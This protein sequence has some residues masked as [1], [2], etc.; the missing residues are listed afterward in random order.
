VQL[1]AAVSA[2]DAQLAS[3]AEVMAT[4]RGDL[5]E[6]RAQAAELEERLAA[7]AAPGGGFE[8]DGDAERP[9]GGWGALASPMGRSPCHVAGGGGFAERLMEG[10]APLEQLHYQVGPCGAWS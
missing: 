10:D 4:L 9:H 1:R 3:S 6:A 7:V 2:R 8:T 5:A